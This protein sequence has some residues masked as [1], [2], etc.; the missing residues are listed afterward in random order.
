MLMKG[1]KLRDNQG[2]ARML[3]KGKALIALFSAKL[4]KFMR[5]PLVRRSD[6]PTKS[7]VVVCEGRDGSL[8]IE[9]RGR[10]L[11]WQEIPPPPRPSV[12]ET[13]PPGH[14][15]VTPGPPA[16]QLGKRKPVAV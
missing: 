10:A 16:P 5:I 7:Q 6:A 12:Q 4:H 11:R 15:G 13:T 9:Y 3:L 2:K 1:N 8:V 14:S